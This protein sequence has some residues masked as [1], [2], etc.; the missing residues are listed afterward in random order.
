MHNSGHTPVYRLGSRGIG[1]LGEG[2]TQKFPYMMQ[3]VLHFCSTIY[4][5][6]FYLQIIKRVNFK[7][8]HGTLWRIYLGSTHGEG[9][10]NHSPWNSVFIMVN[11]KRWM[12]K[13]VGVMKMLAFVWQF[14]VS[15]YKIAIFMFIFT[16]IVNACISLVKG[17][18]VSAASERFGKLCKS[19]KKN[20]SCVVFF[21]SNTK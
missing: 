12:G 3:Y 15:E 14:F 18:S 6:K 16:G 10:T 13:P 8:N 17:N 20:V 4:V 1:L 5:H 7:H 19:K 2:T 11:F 9:A 21:Q